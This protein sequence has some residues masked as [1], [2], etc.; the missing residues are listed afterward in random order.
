MDPTRSGRWGV[1]Q[2][3]HLGEN[4][5]GGTVGMGWATRERAATANPPM[6]GYTFEPF[7]RWEVDRD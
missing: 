2:I 1:R 6:G 3:N 5:G 4:T 7:P